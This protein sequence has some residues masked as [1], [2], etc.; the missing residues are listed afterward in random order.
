MELK[1]DINYKLIPPGVPMTSGATIKNYM[2][3]YLNIFNDLN[4]SKYYWL[5]SYPDMLIWVEVLE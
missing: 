4:L 1:K 2:M 3:T 5:S